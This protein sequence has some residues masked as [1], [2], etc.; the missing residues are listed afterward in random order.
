M[1]GKVYN[2]MNWP[3][4][5]GITYCE[6]DKP[7]ELL[8]GH[9]VKEGFLIQIFRPDAVD[10]KV[11]VSGVNRKYTCDKVDEAGYFAVLIPGKKK[12]E[13]TVRVE[14]VKGRSSEYIDPF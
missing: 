14:D 13:Y 6:S 12:V 8:G 3:E 10:V 2:L 9:L 5:E 4:I 7:G 1:N 11:S